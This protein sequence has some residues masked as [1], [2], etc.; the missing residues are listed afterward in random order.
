MST[1]A[2]STKFPTTLAISGDMVFGPSTVRD[3]V[4]EIAG[5][6]L[7][8]KTSIKALLS[9]WGRN[10]ITEGLYLLTQCAM[11]THPLR[12]NISEQM[13]ARLVPEDFDGSIPENASLIPV[14]AYLSGIGVLKQVDPTKKSGIITGF[15]FLGRNVGWVEWSLHVS[16]EDNPRWN[17]WLLP[18]PRSLVSFDAVIDRV[19]EEGNVHCSLRR[20]FVIDAASQALLTA[21]KID[22]GAKSDRA[23]LILGYRSK[24]PLETASSVQDGT[25]PT[26]PTLEGFQRPT[27]PPLTTPTKTT[28]GDDVPLQ[29]GAPRMTRGAAGS[30]TETPP[31]PTP[32]QQTRKRARLE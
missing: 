5:H 10:P 32:T 1:S 4:L 27:L 26:K 15:V 16:F 25:S 14:L 19:D 9:M 20:I 12:I 21:L 22:G 30:V 6:I 18:S 23:S 28:N 7:N 8:A 17:H 29:P 3:N 2:R 13:C 11:A 24:R 31:S